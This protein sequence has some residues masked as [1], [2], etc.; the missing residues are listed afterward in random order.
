MGKRSLVIASQGF[1]KP[2]SMKQENKSPNYT[3]RW[4]DV[5]VVG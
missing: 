5:P 4:D 1:S 3:T 2:W